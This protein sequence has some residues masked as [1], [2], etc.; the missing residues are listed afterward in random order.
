MAMDGDTLGKAIADAIMD[1]DASDGAKKAVLAIW[2][3]IG[4]CIVEHI[5]D[6]IEV[7]IPTG[8][9]IVEVTGQ[10]KGAPNSAP[11]ALDVDA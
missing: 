11:I 5:V 9:V 7:T 10:A 4:G 2:K 1:N 3:K 8:N 6:N